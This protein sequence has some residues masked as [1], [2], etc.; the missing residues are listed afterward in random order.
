MKSI[1][2]VLLTVTTIACASDTGVAP[3]PPVP[4]TSTASRGGWSATRIEAMRQ[5]LAQGEAALQSFLRLVEAGG[6]A[7]GS[8][9]DKHQRYHADAADVRA[10]IS[11]IHDQFGSLPRSNSMMLLSDGTPVYDDTTKMNWVDGGTWI[12]LYADATPGATFTASSQYS[13]PVLLHTVI[14]GNTSTGWSKS[15]DDGFTVTANIL[16]ISDAARLPS[17]VGRGALR[18]RQATAYSRRLP[19]YATCGR[20]PSILCTRTAI[21]KAC[22]S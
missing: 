8:D 12:K 9:P 4:I 15:S 21:F 10:A 11:R 20:R 19:Y 6:P 5:S 7:H 13:Q 16:G 2:W 18:P 22:E 17:S 1:R 14:R 3:R